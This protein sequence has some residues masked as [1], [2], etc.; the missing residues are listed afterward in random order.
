MGDKNERSN[1]PRFDS[2]SYYRERGY[3][4]HVRKINERKSKMN[5]LYA[6]GGIITLTLFIYLLVALLWPEKFE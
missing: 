4:H 5:P 6:V 1:I 3:R 2:S